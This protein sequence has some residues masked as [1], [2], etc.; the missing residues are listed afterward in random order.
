MALTFSTFT[1]KRATI[2]AL[3]AAGLATSC[4]G[5]SSQFGE[6][7][8]GD[9]S[10]QDG[11][12]S[13]GG[14]GATC[15]NGT[16]CNTGLACASGTCAPS[17]PSDAAADSP[18]AFM[19]ADVAGDVARA[20]EAGD[21]SAPADATT[22]E[23][24]GDSSVADVVVEDT[25]SDVNLSG[26]AGCSVGATQC[27]GNA[28]ET[29]GSNG[30]WGTA[31]AC[32]N[33][34]CAVGV[35]SGSCSPGE[36]Q[37]SG[38]AAVQGCV[39]GVW[40]T[41][42][43]CNNQA[44]V[45][46]GCTGSC[47]PGR[48]ECTSDT[49]VETCST[50][51]MW[52]TTTCTEA[53]V[54]ADDGGSG[55]NCGGLCVPGTT[56]CTSDTQVETC[57]SSGQWGTATTC[58]ATCVEGD[59]G[60]GGNCGACVPGATQCSGNGVQ[61]CSSNG[62]WG[63]VV[64]CGANQTCW[65]GVCAAMF[66]SCAPGGPGMT[67]CGASN[68]SCCTSLA[69]AG[70]T[71]DR[72]YANSGSGATGLAYPA[73][74]SGFRLDKYEVT[75]G[76]FRQFVSAWNGGAG[77]APPVGSGKHAHLNGGQ[78]LANSAS[79]GTYEP[80]WAPSDD[81]TS[82]AGTVTVTNG[83]ASV[84]FSQNQTLAG[85]TILVF[86]SQPG[87]Q[88]ILAF[89]LSAGKAVTLTSNYTGTSTGS[90]TAATIG[91]APTNVNLASCGSFSTWTNSAGSQESLP[92][93]CI[94][95]QE[96]YAFCI[97][98]GG[99]LPSEAEW[100]YAAAGG[101]RELE[102]PWGSTDPG[103]TNLYAIYGANYPSTTGIAPVGTATLGVGLYGQLDLAGNVYEWNLDWYS[104]YVD[105]S[106]DGAYLSDTQPCCNGPLRSLRSGNFLNAAM[107][108]LLPPYRTAATPTNRNNGYGGVGVRCARI[109]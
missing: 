83:S 7:A 21:A 92:I 102:Y 67:N 15:C 40:G 22:G 85:G 43:T 75:V 103:T 105:P 64:A 82:L 66:A 77:Y 3:V 20:P 54:N 37:C 50:T 73:T 16:L 108:Y 57:S 41:P 35:C 12:T 2:V 89:T 28:V 45:N 70:G 11:T 18:D 68:D 56:Q 8:G 88:Y 26:D 58:T 53:C 23:G 74:V 4:G 29:C 97:W 80:G 90:A 99:F 32:V 36:V 72:T 44:C 59:G 65:S 24:G 93:N 6:Q 33:S 14:S 9:A 47:S 81:S 71:Y 61:T 38:N 63:G 52:V 10:D 27:S 60:A 107:P 87:V 96:A 76:R 13:C 48:T 46:G 106:A 78:G 49:Q 91:I 86:A 34:T 31:V 51:G 79:P 69:V 39:S 84:T 42:T 17:V 5:S 100:E 95:W 55:G 62:Q 1:V 104:S 98:D 25:G 94:T 101:S 19:V 109:P 30:Q